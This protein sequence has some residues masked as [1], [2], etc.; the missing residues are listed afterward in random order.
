M[1][2]T[3]E[4]EL[5]WSQAHVEPEE[6]IRVEAK[7]WVVTLARTA[8]RIQPQVPF[9]R[10]LLL[11][12]GKHA[13]PTRSRVVALIPWSL[14]LMLMQVLL[15][16]RLREHH[17]RERF[18]VAFLHGVLLLRKLSSPARR[19]RG[20]AGGQRLHDLVQSPRHQLDQVPLAD[21]LGAI[22]RH[23]PGD[24]VSHG[25]ALD[26]F[27]SLRHGQLGQEHACESG[28]GVYVSRQSGNS[29]S[30]VRV[31]EMEVD[32]RDGRVD[33]VGRALVKVCWY[34]RV[35]QAAEHVGVQV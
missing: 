20:L 25:A 32:N 22:Q 30:H 7:Q 21:C 17:C 8:Q 33:C 15:L 12:G 18:D 31:V 16:V 11:A 19:R 35:P 1:A 23:E 13:H 6:E 3:Q 27:V 29:I 2:V 4:H 28:H 10:N 34:R 14:L 9:C 5:F 26:H 24:E